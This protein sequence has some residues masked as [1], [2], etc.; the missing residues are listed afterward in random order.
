MNYMFVSNKISTL[1]KMAG[2]IAMIPALV[3]S[4]TSGA[5]GS[6]ART[7]TS[8]DKSLEVKSTFTPR[9]NW[10]RKTIAQI[11]SIR[12]N[13]YHKSAILKYNRNDDRGSLDDFNRAIQ[14][15]P[16]SA[17]LYTNRGDLKANH[18]GDYQGALADYNRAIQLEPKVAV[19][20]KARGVLKMEHIRDFQGSLADLNKAI[21]LQPD[22]GLAYA[23]RGVLK[24]GL[25]DRLGGIA[26][27]KKAAMLLKQQGKI[28]DYNV[29]VDLLKKWQ[30]AEQKERKSGR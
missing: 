17:G 28:K 25:N 7:T 16:G 29:A 10:R 2:V 19:H 30:E 3:I 11:N 20:I 1:A 12:A 15:A 4:L 22:Y 14:L 5:S 9:Q 18:L 26:D 8:L 6:I 27:T 13:E 21:Q 24:H 23:Y